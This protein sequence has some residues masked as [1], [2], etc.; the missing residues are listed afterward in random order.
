VFQREATQRDHLE[1][2][3]QNLEQRMK[4]RSGTQIDGS[5][6]ATSMD[7]AAAQYQVP[8]QCSVPHPAGAACQ[9]CA[10]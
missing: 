2:Q 1:L 6:T 5:D 4:P 7:E 9:L 10:D 3:L 8:L